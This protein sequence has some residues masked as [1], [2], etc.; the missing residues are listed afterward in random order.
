MRDV[1]KTNVNRQQ[2]SKRLHR[3]TRYHAGNVLLVALLVIG[4]GV[5]LSMT[6]F[7]NI[8]TVTINNETD[9]DSMEIVE[10]SGIKSGENLVRMDTSASQ[11]RIA[12]AL[13]YA[14]D[15]KVSKKYPSEVEITVTRA[16]PIANIR[17]SFGYLLVS[18]SGKILGAVEE[19]D[20]SLLVIDG[21]EP[22]TDVAGEKLQSKD[23][24]KD[25]VLLTLTNAVT[26]NPD[27]NIRSLDMSDIY[28]IQVQF[29]D[30]VQ[31][32]MGTS[33][34]AA[35]KLRLAAAAIKQ[36]TVSKSYHLTMVGN[37]MVSAISDD[38]AKVVHTPNKEDTAET[39]TENAN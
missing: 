15:V 6:L 18:S 23:P 25:S 13:V 22:A 37:N 10:L 30:K 20:A 31:F 38:S 16:V 4:V 19:P 5:S 36:L 32:S 35:Y 28:E 34:E 33:N 12:E 11:K 7:F 27:A 26:E 3:R 17:Y 1:I 24:D 9:Y 8:T 14:E 39:T 29:G 2:S 21:F